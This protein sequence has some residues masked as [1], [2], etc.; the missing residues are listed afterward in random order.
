MTSLIEGVGRD[1]LQKCIDKFQDGLQWYLVVKS[2]AN[3]IQT[4]T[5]PGVNWKSAQ[6]RMHLTA[7]AVGVLTFLAGFGVCWL[8]FVR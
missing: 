2:K 8:W 6:H 5:N 7:I 1:E 4:T 3:F